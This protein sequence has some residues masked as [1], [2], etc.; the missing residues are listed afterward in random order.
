MLLALR[1]AGADLFALLLFFVARPYSMVTADRLRNVYDV[2]RDVERRRVPGAFVECGVWRGGC[3]AIMAAVAQR[4]GSGR[5]I[6][7][8][9]SFEGLPAPTAP[10]GTKAAEWAGA[11]G[12]AELGRADRLVASEQDVRD[13]LARAGVDRGPIEIRT[14]WF[15]STLPAARAEIGPIA[16]LRLDGDWYESTMTC[17]ENLYDQVAPGGTVIVDDYDYWEGARRA[18]DEFLA[19]RGERVTLRPVRKGA[20][21]DGRYF[22]KTEAA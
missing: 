18:V 5:R 22:T 16:L 10:D 1:A 2:A 4:A 20:F 17:L 15:Q 8:F 11:P 3:A 12:A 6:W 21:A 7:L 14:G 9:D 13:V 19:R